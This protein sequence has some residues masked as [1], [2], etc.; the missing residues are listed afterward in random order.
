MISISLN[1]LAVYFDFPVR[2]VAS[3]TLCGCASQRCSHRVSPSL[4]NQKD[5]VI[6]ESDGVKHVLTIDGDEH[7]A[8]ERPAVCHYTV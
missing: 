5:L 8:T 6:C 2:D 3:E 1:Y 4:K 7:P